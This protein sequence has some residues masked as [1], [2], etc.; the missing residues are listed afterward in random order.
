MEREGSIAL[1]FQVAFSFISL[2][3]DNVL[4]YVYICEYNNLGDT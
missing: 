4:N 3:K 1:L 2:A